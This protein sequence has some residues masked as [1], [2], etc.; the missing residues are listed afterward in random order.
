MAQKHCVGP[1]HSIF[2]PLAK[3][4]GKFPEIAG[5]ELERIT[6]KEPQMWPLKRC[7]RGKIC[8]DKQN[9]QAGLKENKSHVALKL[10]FFFPCKDTFLSVGQCLQKKIQYPSAHTVPSLFR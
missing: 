8:S 10:G 2:N 6:F 5:R 7:P 4:K 1:E 9:I 3:A